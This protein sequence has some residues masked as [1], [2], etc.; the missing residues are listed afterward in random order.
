VPELLRLRSRSSS[1]AC[2]LLSFALLGCEPADPLDAIRKQQAAGDFAGSVEPLRELLAQRPQDPEANFLY[3]MALI[4]SA[5]P[6]LALFPLRQAM[7]DPAWLVP[8]GMQVAQAAL[9]TGDFNEAVH[10][11]TRILEQ[12][13]EEVQ[14]TLFRAQAH[15]HWKQDPEA[16]LADADKVLELQPEMIEAYEPKILA[17]LALDRPAEA[18]AALEEAGRRLPGSGAP[19]SVLAWHCSTTAVFAAEAGELDRAREGFRA[20]LAEYPADA[21]LVPTAVEFYDSHD[22]MPRSI[23]VLRAALAAAP[24]QRNFRTALADRLRAVGSTAEGEALLREATGTEDPALAA[25]AWTDLARFRQ[26]LREHAAAAEALERAVALS[27]GSGELDPQ[28]L[29]HFADALVLSGQLDRAHAVAEEISVPALRRLIAG[30]VA[31]ERGQPA[32]ALA[33]FDEALRVWPNNASAHYYAALAAEKLGDF[34][35][36]LEEYRYSIRISQQA[37]DA[38]TRAARLLIAEGQPLLAYQLLF[39]E[40]AKAPL[41]P[42]GQLLSL[43]LMAL[44]ANPQQLQSTLLALRERDPAR[45]AQGLARGAEGAA[46][47][48][49][50]AAALPLLL[51]APDIDY[52][53]PLAIP[54]L[55]VLV[56]LAHAAGEPALAQRAVD[57]ALA[58]HP[59]AAV[60]HEVQGLHR[61]LGG[62]AP[63]EARAAYARALELDPGNAGALAGLGRLV[64]SSDPEQALALFDRAAAA[65][66]AD[67]EARLAA[68]RALRA[69][70]RPEEAARRLDALLEQHPFEWQAAAEL[71]S[72]DLERGMPNAKTLER[73][74][75]AARF[76][77]GAPAWD[78][79]SELHARLE[80][81]AEAAEAAEHARRLRESEAARQKASAGPASGS[82]GI[83][84][85]PV[86][87]VDP[88]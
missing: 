8:A 20:C 52:G 77:G 87:A 64:A 85:A 19:E 31:Q 29:F 12:H 13:P 10:A 15:A 81:P 41:E 25:A 62:A 45:Y 30:R 79:L 60:F 28:L 65:D 6:S 56:R 78:R 16:A 26:A 59:A 72:L 83:E 75:R 11:T 67:P 40:V 66:P 73:A 18:R 17:L 38:R 22:G 55:R 9:V 46:D 44:V 33:E 24:A 80:Q 82:T 37:T 53:D 61:E 14:A 42:E 48:A 34:D 21:T 54:A 88:A 84:P 63:E 7:Q 71:V 4:F 69:S 70:G 57:A 1:L 2:L 51:D 36:A 35:R 58:A 86:P 76:G 5:Q 49:G 27:R 23:E 68:A 39:L 32:R 74:R 43:Y 50:A 47:R 3:G